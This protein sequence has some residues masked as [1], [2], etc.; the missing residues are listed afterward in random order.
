[1]PDNEVD[2]VTELCEACG[3]RSRVSERW[4][5]SCADASDE[6]WMAEAQAAETL[7]LPRRDVA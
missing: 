7:G 4:C 1:M 2:P 6:L 5:Q 3:L